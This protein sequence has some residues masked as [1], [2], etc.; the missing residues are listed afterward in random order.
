LFANTALSVEP[1]SLE[2]VCRLRDPDLLERYSQ[3]LSRCEPGPWQSGI[4]GPGSGSAPDV[5][6]TGTRVFPQAWATLPLLA[7]EA[8]ADLLPLRRRESCQGRQDG[9]RS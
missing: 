3:R 1:L 6:G 9:S 7:L 5:G 8:F 2:A 4:T